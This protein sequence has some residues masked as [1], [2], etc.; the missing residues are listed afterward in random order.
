MGFFHNFERCLAA[1]PAE[2]AFVALAD[3]DDVWNPDKLESLLAAF[4]PDTQLVYSDMRVVRPD[5][6]VLAG[7]FWTSRRNNWTDF[8]SLLMANTVT[9]AAS[10]FR[11]SLLCD[12][13]PFPPR[14]GH[15]YHDHWLAAVALCRGRIR[16]VDRPLYD[17]VQ[18]G[19]N[20]IGHV[21]A[22]ALGWPTMFGGLAWRCCTPRRASR[23]CRGLI[24]SGRF[25]FFTELLHVQQMAQVLELRCGDRL[26]PDKRRAVSR[27]ASLT[28]SAAVLPWLGKRW[29]R[30]ANRPTETLY[31]EYELLLG[32]FWRAV[33][34]FGAAIRPVARVVAA[35]RQRPGPF[36]PQPAKSDL[37]RNARKDR[38]MSALIKKCFRRAKLVAS[39]GWRAMRWPM[40]H[41]RL[42]GR[43]EF[44]VFCHA[45]NSLLPARFRTVNSV[46]AV[47]PMELPSAA[48]PY[49]V[50]VANNRWNELRQA[51]AQEEV[52]RLPRRPL[53]SVVM[54]VYNIDA[55]WL[56]KAVASVTAQIYADWELCIADD[57]STDPHIAPLLSHYAALDGR[58]RV[59]FLETNGN[60]SAATNAAAELAHGEFLVLLDQDDELT[61]DCLLELAKAVVAHPDADVIYSDSDKM[62][63]NGQRYAPEFK[64][65]WSPELLLSF[66]YFSHVF[67]VRRSIF[68]E[69]GGCRR[70]FEGTQDHD[71]ALRA[72]ERAR[73]V[74][75]VPKLLYHW[76]A[77][78]TSVAAD[79]AVKRGAFERGV[80]AV[81]DALRRR[82]VPGHVTRP[83]WAVANRNGIYQISFPDT[84]PSVAIVIPTKNR[85]DLLHRCVE[86]IVR[87]TT[88]ENY[89]IVVIDNDSD[90][91]ATLAYFR[92][93]PAKC[94]VI[95]VGNENGRFSYARVN[96]Q[97]VK[98]LDSDFV[99]F[100][101]NDTQVLEPAWLSDLVGY[102][103]LP[104]VGAVG[105]RL[106][107]PDGRVQHAGV[108]TGWP[109][110][111]GY[112]A[113]AFKLRA[114]DDPG[115]M[116]FS[117][118][119]RNTSAV[120]AACMLVGRQLFLDA[121]GFDEERFAVA[122]NDVDLCLRLRERGLRCVYAP[123]AF[124]VHYENATRGGTDDQRE[125]REYQR[126][127]GADRDPYSNPNFARDAEPFS[128]DSRCAAPTL[129]A[130]HRAV[131]VLFA[132]HNLNAEGAQLCLYEI[133]TALGR[134]GRIAAE[135][136]SPQDGPLAEMYRDHGIPVHVFPGPLG[137]VLD[138]TARGKFTVADYD[139]GVDSLARWLKG[140][141]YKAVH[142]NTL[143]LHYVVDAAKRAGVPSLWNVHESHDWR[144]YWHRRYDF[145]DLLAGLAWRCFTYP[146]RIVYVSTPSR[147][148]YEEL[149][150]RSNFTVVH[151]GLA[152]QAIDEFMA[153]QNQAECKD[154]VG[155]PQQ[156]KLVTIIGHV[157]PHKRQA[158]FARAAVELLQHGR[159]DTV[160][161]IVGCKPNGYLEVVKE[162][163]KGHEDRIRLI[164]PTKD[165]FPYFRASDVFVCCSDNESYPRVILESM[166]FRLPLVTT[167][168]CGIRE[169]V[170]PGVSALTYSPGNVEALAAHIDRLLNNPAERARLGEAA[171][172]V[173]DMLPTREEMLDAYEQILL[174]A[175]VASGKPITSPA[176]PAAAEIA[177]MARAA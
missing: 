72:T 126:A 8:P 86:S 44:R 122:Y 152:R 42:P 116:A 61:P 13:L 118:V 101:N 60:I 83:D 177:P 124:L 56:E 37:P 107:Y 145:T 3:Q 38:F 19:G 31:R 155:C 113:H 176:L 129:P 54:P 22:A 40:R 102:G 7:T 53:L 140:F 115:Y 78:P 9:G 32:L 2:A 81:Q 97:A 34:R 146:Y 148:L 46:P 4:D 104:G 128:L 49:E 154:S 163:V 48:A 64:P 156:M 167:T 165:V 35:H 134:R 96:N 33:A 136:W 62:D 17:Y 14:F 91:P 70:G 39:L 21:Q 63:E 29:L 166:A 138:G 88:Y 137:R 89:S 47:A 58:I 144:T 15:M 127:W 171:G 161:A 1:V 90:D 73:Q 158:D 75:H 76:R 50:W 112:A 149:N 10:M 103:Q 142:V 30:H 27:M 110:N 74:V 69:V 130:R 105:A 82:G 67:A 159:R 94:R 55:Q 36:P 16:Y 100:L 71:L 68:A 99:L 98:A 111:Q 66:M 175:Y 133:A 24:D 151:N 18:H 119:A 28:R 12:A 157:Y 162:V 143:D 80:R 51:V 160:F 23:Y 43:H 141:G 147:H 108:V 87:K 139:E 135:V 26:D 93:L 109:R 52:G 174:E 114:G 132:S 65:D 125:V 117:L 5:G 11:R 106:V 59:R 45:A 84:G 41:R 57:A 95:R 150:L 120:T 153:D 172:L 169:Q 131:R 20:V 6:T 25:F 77:L 85:V 79:G 173:L 164:P 168:V 121:G 170:V 123:H 92:M